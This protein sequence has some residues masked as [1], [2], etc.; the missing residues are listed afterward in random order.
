MPSPTPDIIRARVEA[1]HAAVAL[2]L[3]AHQQA[4]EPAAAI[5][6]AAIAGPASTR[7]AAIEAATTA[8]DEALALGGTEA[9]L[10]A[11]REAHR[12]VLAQADA[13]FALATTSA[14]EA[15]EAVAAAAKGELDQRTSERWLDVWRE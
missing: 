12:A 9:H 4:V 2:L 11:V 10:E 5:Y 13:D 14:R 15:Y 6:Q 3:A 8:R 1:Y 7:D